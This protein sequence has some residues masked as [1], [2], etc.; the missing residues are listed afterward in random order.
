MLGVHSLMAG[1]RARG[2]GEAARK[3]SNRG[4]RGVCD[5]GSDHWGR[6]IVQACDVQCR[7]ARAVGRGSTR[8]THRD[9]F[10]HGLCG[11]HAA[12]PLSIPVGQHAA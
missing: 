3:C 4:N 1:Q 6:C 11:L 7:D 12:L 10:G 9:G 5:L 2:E 8:G